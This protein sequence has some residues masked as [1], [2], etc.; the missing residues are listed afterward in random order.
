MKL[1]QAPHPVIYLR[2]VKY[3]NLQNLLSFIYEEEAF[4]V[5]EYLPSFLEV[6]EDLNI[7]CLCEKKNVR[8]KLKIILKRKLAK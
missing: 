2:K 7:R 4:V 6:T 1:N 3:M 5:K 8:L